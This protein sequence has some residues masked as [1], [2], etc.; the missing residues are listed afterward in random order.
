MGM[1]NNAYFRLIAQNERGVVSFQHPTQPGP[2]KGG[3]MQTM[4]VRKVSQVW[5]PKEQC[6]VLEKED[7]YVPPKAKFSMK[8][9]AKHSTLK[10]CWIIVQ[11]LVYDV[12]KFLEEHP[13]GKA[14][15]LM[16]AGTDCTADFDAI[17]SKRAWS[18]LREYCIGSI[19]DPIKS[20]D[21]TIEKVV[22]TVVEIVKTSPTSKL[23]RFESSFPISDFMPGHHVIFCINGV[24]RAYTPVAV[25]NC[26]TQ[27]DFLIR[28]YPRGEMS[29]LLAQIHVHSCIE[30]KA[31]VGHIFKTHPG[32]LTLR[33][34]HVVISK[35]GLVAAGTGIT[36]MLA[37]LHTFLKEP[38]TLLVNLLYSNK[39]YAEILMHKELLEMERKFD[40]LKL[41]FTLTQE[42]PPLQLQEI[43]STGRVT[44]LMIDT[45]ILIGDKNKPEEKLDCVLVCGPQLFIDCVCDPVFQNVQNVVYA[46]F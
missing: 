21:I 28:L 37:L 33:K 9:V 35:L 12:T 16:K 26:K 22:L 32:A 6:L 41:H 11:N 4:T 19:F 5:K 24:L 10:D 1:M 43:C 44:K 14:S 17:H 38:T 27:F 30:A 13:G 7:E 20:D 46:Q 36:P 23:F 18:Q 25:S 45:H 31:P 42:D 3:W 34:T 39:T 40:A 8:T 15:I 2:L 29:Q